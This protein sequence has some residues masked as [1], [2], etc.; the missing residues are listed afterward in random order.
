MGGGA[1]INFSKVTYP[2]PESR[3]SLKGDSIQKHK[4]KTKETFRSADYADWRRL[5]PS[6]L[7]LR[8]VNQGQNHASRGGA[9]AQGKTI[10]FSPASRVKPKTNKGS[11]M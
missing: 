9:E 7:R 1:V 5:G 6:I 10:L 2:G 3:A 8:R 11:V 4:S